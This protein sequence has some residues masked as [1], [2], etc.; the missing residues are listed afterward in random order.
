[1]N[2]IV[3]RAWRRQDTPEPLPEGQ[4][5]GHARHAAPSALHDVLDAPPPPADLP[6]AYYDRVRTEIEDIITTSLGGGPLA[7][8]DAA[9]AADSVARW[10]ATL[11]EHQHEDAERGRHAMALLHRAVM[12]PIH[13][14]PDGTRV[15]LTEDLKLSLGF[16]ARA[17]LGSDQ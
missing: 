5:T 7:R 3:R 1:M 8:F 13:T 14:L 6:A 11:T 15:V 12:V 10:V 17:L 16:Q 4:D 9:R 2:S